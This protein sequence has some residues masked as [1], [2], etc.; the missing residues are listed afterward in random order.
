MNK[1]FNKHSLN[2]FLSLRTRAQRAGI[3]HKKKSPI[4]FIFGCKLV[5]SISPKVK[6]KS[7]DTCSPM[8]PLCRGLKKKWVLDGVSFHPG[9]LYLCPEG[10]NIL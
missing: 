4:D 1:I 7:Y 6:S 5:K 9:P 8:Q 2:L 10:Q 3:G